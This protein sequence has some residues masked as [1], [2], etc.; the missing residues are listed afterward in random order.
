MLNGVPIK[1]QHV[2]Y[3]DFFNILGV[4]LVCCNALDPL[5]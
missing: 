2:N 1:S 5:P 4:A 3:G